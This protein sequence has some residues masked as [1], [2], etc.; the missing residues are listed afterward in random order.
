MEHEGIYLLRERE[1]V[2]L[3]E[4]VYKIGRSG[5]IKSR[6]SKYPKGSEIELMMSCNDSVQCERELLKIF[7]RVFKH[8]PD[9]GDEYF[10]GDKR[11]MIKIIT[12]YINS[13]TTI[14]TTT[15]LSE[16]PIKIEIISELINK[17]NNANINANINANTTNILDM[18]DM[19]EADTAKGIDVGINIDTL[20]TIITNDINKM[21]ILEYDEKLYWQ[22]K[23][24]KI[25]EITSDNGIGDYIGI[26]D[27]N[28]KIIH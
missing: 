8:C 12:N 15:T 5:H 25:Y 2:R 7:N 22:D 17:H 18:M 9:Y 26:L 16:P 20:D 13:I 14:N 4:D 6:I 19:I 1:F 24:N 27:N 11:L 3:K 23:N 10:S 21:S 28:K